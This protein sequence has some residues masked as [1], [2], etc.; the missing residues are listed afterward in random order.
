MTRCNAVLL[1]WWMINNFLSYE[2][3]PV[4]VIIDIVVEILW[5]WLISFANL[6][7]LNFDLERDAHQWLS[8]TLTSQD[9]HDTEFC[10]PS[11]NLLVI[12]SN[13]W[14][15]FCFIL[16]IQPAFG[17]QFIFRSGLGIELFNLERPKY[18]VNQVQS[19]CLL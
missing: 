19:L 16:L 2:K 18:C 14:R 5:P 11:L 7:S 12:V 8:Q 3:V 13:V 10:S 9:L 6:M 15:V 17:H 1:Y 4:L